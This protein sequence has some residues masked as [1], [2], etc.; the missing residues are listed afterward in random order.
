[1]DQDYSRSWLHAPLPA[2]DGTFSTQEADLALAAEDFG[3]DLHRLPAA[4]LFPGSIA[5]VVRVVQFAR[6]NGVPIAPR[7]QG[8]STGGQSQA[9]AGIVVSMSTL[10]T[11]GALHADHIEVEA[12]VLWSMLLQTTQ[13][14]GLTPPVLPDY[15]D[16]TVG[17]VLSV[18]GISGT[19]YWYGAIVDTVLELQV[20]TGA[21]TLETCSPTQQ[22]ELFEHVLAGLGQCGMIVKATLQL[23]PAQSHARVFHLVYPHLSA[24]IQDQQLLLREHRFDF[25]AGHIQLTPQETWSYIL[26]AVSF[27]TPSIAEP[28]TEH[29]LKQLCF[30]PGSERREETSYLAFSRRVVDQVDQLKAMG[31]WQRPHPWFDVFVPTSQIE[32]YVNEILTEVA[33]ADVGM[34]PMLL[35]G[36]QRSQLHRTLLCIPAEETVFLF[37]ILRTVVPTEDVVRKMIAQNRRFLKRCEERGGTCYPIGSLE[38]TPH[39]WKLQFGSVWETFNRMKERFDPDHVL[40]PGPG[41]F[42][43]LEKEGR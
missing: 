9:E 37:D 31:I 43:P 33:P 41:I 22:P 20:V 29:L 17:G 18:G 12:G 19:S 34:L 25:L 2:F 35:Y 15:L 28:E 14:H 13:A 26:E 4:V 23:L 39:D 7:G 16:L 38:L 8:H 24:L 30:L 27:Y 3:H 5:D 1:M 32:Q 40:T 10:N 21:G 11:I 6:Q 36:L 42:L